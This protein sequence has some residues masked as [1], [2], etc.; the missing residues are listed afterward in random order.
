[1]GNWFRNLSVK[2]KLTACFGM[3]LTLIIA[4]TLLSY[5]GFS[6]VGHTVEDMV[7]QRQPATVLTKDLTAGLERTAASLGYYVATLEPVHR[8]TYLSSL[9]QAQ[10]TLQK[11][12]GLPALK[13]DAQ[14]LGDLEDIAGNI[15]KLEDVGRRIL[16][17][18]GNNEAT[19]PGIQFANGDINPLTRAV[20]QLTETMMLSESEEEAEAKRRP[21]LLAIAEL[22]YS[23]SN[24]MRG[25]RGYLA[26]RNDQLLDE[27]RL[28]LER[29]FKYNDEIAEYGYLLTLE[30]EEANGQIAERIS[31][32]SGKLDQLQ[33]IHSGPR[34]RTDSWLVAQ[35]MLP[36]FAAIQQRAG[37]LAGRQTAAMTAAGSTLVDETRRSAVIVAVISVVGVL[38]GLLF[39]WLSGHLVARPM[40]ITA[41][42]LREIADGGGDLT[43]RLPASRGDEVG[44]LAASFNA[45]VERITDLV[46]HTA[47]ATGHVIAGVAEASDRT[48][49]IT[50]RVLDQEAQTTAVATAMEEMSVSIK[51]VAR[52]AI[53]AEE[54]ANAALAKAAAGGETVERTARSGG[55]LVAQ[56]EAAAEA[57]GNLEHDAEA[58]GSV[59]D[60]IKTIAEQTNLL[61]LNAAIEAARAGEQGR[62]FAVVADEVRGL[63][64]RTQQSTGEIQQIIERVQSGARQAV[65]AMVSGKRKAEQNAEEAG[66]AREAL[67]EIQQQVQSISE[68]NVQIATAAQ[69]QSHVAEEINTNVSSISNASRDNAESARLAR[70]TTDKLAELA[71]ELQQVIGRFRLTGDAGLDFESAKAAHLAWKARLN[72]FLEGNATMT[73]DEAVSHHDCILGK[74]YY[75]EGLKKYR[76]IPQMQALEA[77]HA[78][79]HKLIRAII[80]KK[81]AGRDGEART[82]FEQIDPLSR[83]IIGLLNEVEQ[84]TM[85]SKA[86]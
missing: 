64:N 26:F 61:A 46:R 55:E 16:E 33:A 6:R 59:L 66:R 82:L 32:L 1:M 83:Q 11:L 53:A 8:E 18:A 81:N 43:V 29:S 10:G 34:W 58:V 36:L 3:M 40:R 85:M 49:Q 75:G 79:L 39:A 20:S 38:S 52:N 24:V 5:L 63:A 78:Q 74:W 80:E 19:Y 21:L 27:T 67:C 35:E 65:T 86:A 45:F 50:H 23:W 47:Q 72:A 4:V 30:Q 48:D 28:Y 42:A 37:E 7:Q 41:S 71:N 12:R 57:I 17:T 2:H 13:A 44:Q 77:P 15:A 73:R 9:A 31:A 22:R 76:H 69:Q 70:E 25:L 84:Q 14:A 68:V 56:M 51:E 54:T 62:G 60:V